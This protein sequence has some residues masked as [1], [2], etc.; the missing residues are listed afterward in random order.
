MSDR[1]MLDVRGRLRV[2][3]QQ[4][5]DVDIVIQLAGKGFGNG[6]IVGN[7]Q[8]LIRRHVPHQNDPR[9]PAQRANREK[10]KAAV[11]AWR[12]LPETERQRHH[13]EAKAEGRTGWNRFI[14]EYL[15]QS[16]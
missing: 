5:K 13:T 15:H 7:R 1:L 3:D 6:R 11:A 12:A 9:T 2:K 14:A 4:G 10:F 16:C 8:Y